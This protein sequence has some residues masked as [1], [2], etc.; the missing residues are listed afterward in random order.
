MSSNINQ[1]LASYILAQLSLFQ[2]YEHTQVML[3]SNKHNNSAL[4]NL[5]S[6]FET[7]TLN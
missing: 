1:L 6:N 3:Y 5:L 7:I 4:L 2:F